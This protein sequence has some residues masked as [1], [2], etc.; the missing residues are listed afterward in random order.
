MST[1]DKDF[2][3]NAYSVL[4]PLRYYGWKVLENERDIP[5]SDDG[6][7]TIIMPTA[8]LIAM[9]NALNECETFFT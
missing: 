9:Q 7:S 3:V 8:D 5:G 6:T 2:Y 1:V 4:Q